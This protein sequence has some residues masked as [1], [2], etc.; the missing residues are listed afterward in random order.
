MVLPA[1]QARKAQWDPPAQPV[2]ESL[3]L[4]ENE[5]PPVLPALKAKPAQPAR[6]EQLPLV[7]LAQQAPSVPLALREQSE[8]PES[9]AAVPLA[10]A[11][12]LAQPVRLAHRA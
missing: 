7:P 11:V 2:P 4:Q 3:A 10:R 6:Q 1:P 9:K 12:P 8:E 5:V